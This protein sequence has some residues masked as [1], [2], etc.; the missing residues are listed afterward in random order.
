MVDGRATPAVDHGCRAGC[1]RPWATAGTDPHRL[2]PASVSADVE[3]H[4]PASSG[5]G[6]HRPAS[7]GI[8]RHRAASAGIER[9]RLTSTS[10]DIEWHRPVPGGIGI[11]R[12]WAALNGR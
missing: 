7:S 6:R 1:G 2:T 12:H 8:G 3:R 10:A 4:R 11:G 5:I 9:H